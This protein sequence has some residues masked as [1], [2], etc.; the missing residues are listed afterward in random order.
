MYI[1]ETI[2]FP[3]HTSF[4]NGGSKGTEGVINS[5]MNLIRWCYIAYAL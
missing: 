5:S 4:R 3:E 2:F 1:F